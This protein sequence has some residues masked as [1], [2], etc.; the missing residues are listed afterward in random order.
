MDGESQYNPDKS[1]EDISSQLS[2]TVTLANQ[3]GGV[4]KTTTAVNLGACLAE[5]GHRVLLVDAD[6]QGNATTGLGVDR[7]AIKVGTYEVL[8][9]HPAEE[10]VAP[11]EVERLWMLPSTIDL[12]GAEIELVSTFAREGRLRQALAGVRPRFDFVLVDSP[13]S[14]GLLTVNALTAADRVLI[15][16]QTEYYAL[17]GLGQLM[18]TI[19]LVRDTLNPMLDLGGVLLTMYDGRTKLAEQV[20]AEVRRHFGEAVFETVIPR[21]VRLSE[22]PSYGRPIVRYDPS[23]RGAQAYRALAREAL[24]RW[25]AREGAQGPREEAR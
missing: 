13:P 5:A 9:G 17:E 12:A 18:R 6:P 21:S 15:P 1:K 10:A 16:V 3:K 20:A 24:G 7:G 19:E 8:A 23:S 2:L 14:L 4:G 11:T 25:A 22:A